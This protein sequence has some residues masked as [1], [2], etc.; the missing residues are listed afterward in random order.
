MGCLT[1]ARLR[2]FCCSPLGAFVGKISVSP[3]R[4]RSY[5]A[6]ERSR[7]C[8]DATN[9]WCGISAHALKLAGVVGP[10]PFGAGGDRRKGDAYP[11]RFSGPRLARGGRTAQRWRRGRRPC[12]YLVTERHRLSGRDL[13]LRAAWRA[14]RPYQ[15]ALSCSRSRQPAAS[16]ARG[17]AGDAVGIRARRLSSDFCGSTYPGS[18]QSPLCTCTAKGPQCHHA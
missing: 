11:G 12:C 9:I 4:P 2:R 13:C 17:R 15:Y 14:G 5:R 18:G 16:N 10:K 6:K 8:T 1:A 3:G 7:R